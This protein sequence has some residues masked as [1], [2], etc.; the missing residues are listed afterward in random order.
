[1]FLRGR[2][3]FF[4]G[5]VTLGLAISLGAFLHYHI[6]LILKNMTTNEAH[7]WSKVKSAYEVWLKNGGKKEEEKEEKSLS[8]SSRKIK[9]SDFEESAPYNSYDKGKL[10]NCIELF[11]GEDKKRK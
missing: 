7:K 11:F 2:V 3:F 10:K 1:M 4:C 9:T 8:Q 6:S 5:G